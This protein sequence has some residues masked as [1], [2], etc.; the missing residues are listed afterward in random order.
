MLKKLLFITALAVAMPATMIADEG[1]WLLPFLK[2]QNSESLKKMGLKLEVD[3]IYSPDEV[4]LKD[5]IVIFGRGCTGEVISDEGLILTNHHCGY[6]SIQ[7]HSSVEHDY[8]TDG[9]WAYSKSEELPTPGLEVRF[10]DKIV[11]VTDSVLVAVKEC[12]DPMKAYD[13]MFLN[14]ISRRLAG[15]DFIKANPFVEVVTKPFY[16]GNKFLMFYQTVYKDVRMVG[17]P[18]SS[19]G[20]YG[21]DTDNWMWPRHT[22]DFSLFRVYTDKDGKAAEY[23]PENIPMK[24][25]HHL[26]ISLKGIKQGDYSM[27]IGFPGT[28]N[29]YDISEEIV[30]YRDI[31][32]AARIEM[33][34]VRL[35]TLNKLMQADDKV[36]IQYASKFASSSN[37]WKNAIGM[38]RGVKKLS[39]IDSKLKAEKEYREWAYANNMPQYAEALDNMIIALQNL[40]PIKYQRQMLREALSTAVEFSKVPNAD[41][42]I[43]ALGSKDKEN[44]NK[45]VKAYK[46]SYAK[47]NDK[48]Y[49][50]EVDRQVSKAMIK[51][52]ISMFPAEQRPD[53]FAFIDKKYKGDTDKFIDDCFNKSIFA[54]SVKFNKFMEKPSAKVLKNDL[55]LKYANSVRAKNRELA[56]STKAYNKDL[57]L[58]KQVY[59]EGLLKMREGTPV[60]PDANFTIR[61]SAGQ[62]QPYKPAD[63]VSYNYFTTMEGIFEKEDSTN[64]EFIVPAKLKEIWQNKD[65]GRYAEEDGTM[66]VNFISSND[67]TGGNSGSPVINGNGELIG[68]AFDGNWEAMSGDIIFE[69]NMQRTISVDIRYVMLII[70]KYAGALNIIEEI[71]FVE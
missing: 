27:T 40:Y 16:G 26:P 19:I 52:Y 15:E 44:I 53:I 20:K 37:Y 1:M 61:M 66:Y 69:P 18:P 33:R 12:G 49:D 60:Y 2:Q 68:L 59:I 41:A 65:Y 51:K 67:I 5:A 58:A 36:R 9:F 71:D 34:G 23:S 35:E 29:R 57:T 54:D 7:Q 4:S 47:F 46:E 22:G 63:A 30:H 6:S 56:L 11:D 31:V 62:V 14:K 48:D 38:N 45:E 13:E 10:I 70:E 39:V 3:D 55:M 24:P 50:P 42:L 8:L 28:T 25:K 32:N 64:Y 43:K 17:T 21:Y